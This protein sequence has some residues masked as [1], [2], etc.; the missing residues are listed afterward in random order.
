[1]NRLTDIE[2]VWNYVKL[3]YKHSQN[4]SWKF[5]EDSSSRTGV[6]TDN[7]FSVRKWGNEKTDRYTK[8][9][10]LFRNDIQTS[11]ECLQKTCKI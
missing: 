8:S 10:K 7:L 4:I 9:S 5:E 3:I 6:I 11:Q 1:M 2:E